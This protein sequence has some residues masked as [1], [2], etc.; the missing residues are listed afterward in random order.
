MTL[1]NMLLTV[2]KT[3]GTKGGKYF[4]QWGT[5]SC[6]LLHGRNFVPYQSSWGVWSNQSSCALGLGHVTFMTVR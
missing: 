6:E 1:Q 4:V 3:R 5:A 2:I